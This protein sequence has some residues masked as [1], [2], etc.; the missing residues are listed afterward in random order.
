M[1][2]VL[3]FYRLPSVIPSIRGVIMSILYIYIY[4]VLKQTRALQAEA[5]YALGK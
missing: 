3:A 5:S 4:I 2:I 1:Y